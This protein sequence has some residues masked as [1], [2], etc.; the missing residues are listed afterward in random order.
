MTE[1]CKAQCQQNFAGNHQTDELIQRID[2]AGKL[3]ELPE[4]A[5][6]NLM[7]YR[8]QKLKLVE[9]DADILKKIERRQ[10]L[11]DA[12]KQQLHT[13][14]A[15]NQDFINALPQNSRAIMQQQE[16]ATSEQ[17]KIFLKTLQGVSL[18]Q[19]VASDMQ[20]YVTLLNKIEADTS[21]NPSQQELEK[22]DILHDELV[23]YNK[24][25]AMP[26]RAQSFL[27]IHQT[28]Q[29]AKHILG[30]GHGI[31]GLLE[32]CEKTPER[33]TPVQALYLNRYFHNKA[34]T[35][36]EKMR[37]DLDKCLAKIDSN[38]VERSK[39]WEELIDSKS[40]QVIE[41]IV[42]Q[43]RAEMRSPKSEPY[44]ASLI[45]G[46]ELVINSEFM[47]LRVAGKTTTKDLK[48]FYV[49]NNEL[50]DK[51]SSYWQEIQNFI[52]SAKK[53]DSIPT[54]LQEFAFRVH[55]GVDI[56]GKYDGYIHYIPDSKVS[57]TLTKVLH[58][59]ND[60]LT[61]MEFNLTKGAVFSIFRHLDEIAVRKNE[62]LKEQ[63]IIGTY[64]LTAPYGHVHLE[65]IFIDPKHFP[66]LMG[67]TKD[68]EL[69]INKLS[70]IYDGYEEKSRKYTYQRNISSADLLQEFPD[71]KILQMVNPLQAGDSYHGI[72]LFMT[73]TALNQQ[74]L[75]AMETEWLRY[76]VPLIKHGEIKTPDEFLV[77][78]AH[79]ASLRDHL[80]LVAINKML[81]TVKTLL[82]Q[83]GESDSQQKLDRL[84]QTISS[85]AIELDEKA[86]ANRDYFLSKLKD[87][88]GRVI[89]PA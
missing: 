70:D 20:S 78:I 73:G 18:S 44:T 8:V 81:V 42:A 25:D 63:Q 37:I 19:V 14:L 53:G 10:S 47:E 50:G 88:K 58:V 29:E 45:D 77:T 64:N 3:S 40:L 7:N 30:V 13:Q 80:K 6:D 2:Q 54:N 56:D 34:D 82:E 84:I 87:A 28:K 51:A 72:A 41:D 36:S 35:V 12:E 9:T 23:R 85:L 62:Q 55:E 68:T 46:V 75:S 31:N 86:R 48:Q 52:V 76:S 1:L 49:E 39:Y 11:T 69:L 22:L 59:V 79:S 33:L 15:G 67:N 26:N 71:S 38:V 74:L 16:Y 17:V 32:I 57:P 61:I 24:L 89:N 21:H 4:T 43:I 66:T 5:F 65:K 83:T 27:E 60:N